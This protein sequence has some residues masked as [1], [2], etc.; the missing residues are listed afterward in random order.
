[1]LGNQMPVGAFAYF[2]FLG[3][4]WNGFWSL[5]DRSLRS[6]GRV[7][8]ALCL[9]QRELVAVMAATLVACFP[10]ASGFFRYFHRQIML[11]WYFLPNKLTWQ[12]HG[13]LTEQLRPELFP[14]PWPGAATAASDPQ[15]Q[16]V[17]TGFFTGLAKGSRTVP[18]SALPLGAWVQPMLIWG[19]MLLAMGAALLSLQTIFHRQWARNEQLSYPVAQVAE[20]FYRRRD[21][22]PGVPDIFRNPL[23]WWG[24]TPV[25]LILGIQYLSAWWP[26]SVPGLSEIFPDL[27]SWSLPIT[28]KIPILRQAYASSWYVNGQTLFFTF[29]G[30]AYFVSSD[31][32][33]SI[34]FAP[35]AMIVVSLI[36]RNANGMVMS[37][38]PLSELRCGGAIGYAAILLWTARRHLAETFRCAFLPRRMRRSRQDEADATA[39]A[40]ARLLLVSFTAFTAILAWMCQSWPMAILFTLLAFTMFL[41]VSR[42][43]CETGIP[44]VQGGWNPINAM[45]A[46]LGYAAIGPKPLTFLWW[47]TAVLTSDARESLMPY[48]GTGEKLADG[49]GI[50]LRRLGRWM[51]WALALA[52]AVAFFAATWSLYN[53]NPM[54]DSWA[55]NYTPTMF[56]D[57]TARAFHSMKS[58]GTFEASAAASPLARLA[59][60]APRATSVHWMLY[61]GVAVLALSAIRFRFSRFP[62]HPAIVV[63][64]GS[65]A[66]N[67]AWGAFLAGWAI[68][69]AVIRFGGGKIYGKLKPAFVG[70]VTG[71]LGMAGAALLAEFGH[72][73]LFGE[74]SSVKGWFLPS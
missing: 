1:M 48:V 64:L 15:Y 35:V 19:P 23:F 38:T 52:A 43:V 27:R 36:Y 57:A 54:L 22:R 16:T 25:F 67:A 28:T 65:Y 37:D 3:L 61:G 70:I 58:A 20:A 29:L 33:L 14:A 13:L 53:F 5:L 47:S 50:G 71:E 17:Y 66:G 11:P 32:A 12:T 59:L 18:L 31:V 46:A 42:I 74:P 8:D 39:V 34:G 51:L 55:A 7:R 2:I 41:V 30:I 44:F 26:Q 56:L 69:Q 10:P 73:M 6:E 9:G 49:A 62:V 21:G 60:A 63:L 45:V 24:F 68:K 4:F 72:Y 40:A